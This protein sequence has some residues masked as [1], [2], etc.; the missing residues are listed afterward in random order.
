MSRLKS[1]II[2]EIIKTE[3]GFVD[4]PS[5]SGGA[6]KY[7]ITERVARSVGFD[8]KM[9][10]LPIGLAQEIYRVRYLDRVRFDEVEKLAPIIAAE[11]ADTAVNMGIRRAGEFLQR[12]LNVLNRNGRDYHDLRVD[13]SI[14]G[15]TIAAL[16]SFTRTRGRSGIDVLYSML[17]TLQ[18]A[19]Y[20]TLAE[21][22]VKDERFVFGWFRNRVD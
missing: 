22:R 10:N 4:D 2:D 11:L 20:V 13:G 18:G 21:R 15:K 16:S 1:K 8:G 3:G 19:F 7:G 17:N 5:D 14:G 6:T 9:I 12:S